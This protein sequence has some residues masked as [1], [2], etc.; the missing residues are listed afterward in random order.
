M[1]IVLSILQRV[2]VNYFYRVNAGF[3][4]FLFFL[5]FGIPN[6]LAQFHMAIINIIIQTPMGLG[7]AML[8]WLL[9][10]FKCM[11]YVVK[12]L[13]NPQQQF[14]FCLNHLS[15]RSCFGYLAYVQALVYMPVLAYSMVA[16]T[17]AFKT[18]YY[19]SM[20]GVLLFSIAVIMLT[21][22]VYLRVLQRR[23]VFNITVV[24]PGTGFRFNKPLF[25]VPLFYV[26]HNRR[27][28]LLVTKFFSLLVLYAF[29]HLYEADQYDIRPL[30]L[31][32][33][34]ATAANSALVYETKAFEDGFMGF[35]KNF[36]FTLTKRFGLMLVMYTLL[37]LPELAFVCKGWPVHFHLVDYAQLLLL[38][39]GL[40][41]IFHGSLYTGDIDTDAYFKIVFA[42]LAMLFFVILYNPGILLEC[43]LLAVSFGLFA[44]YYH[45]FEKKHD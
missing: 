39:I 15:P 4:L 2:I 7:I 40:L 30:L 12:Q 29:I 28:M 25:S 3:F 18:H 33:M 26:L 31:C 44:S 10:N 36:P 19:M 5:L 34:L 37:M 1:S 27:Q 8:L 45:D 23:P 13:R 35:A 6:N 43:L 22:G 42:I 16:A 41:S 21:A 38:S 20:A 32:F 14:L 17:V 9:Y 24:L 11:D